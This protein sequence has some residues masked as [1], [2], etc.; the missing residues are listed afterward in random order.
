MATTQPDQHD[1]VVAHVLM[2]DIVG[3]SK[4]TMDE[5]RVVF[6]ELNLVVRAT[7]E[8][9]RADVA[10]QLISLPT[11]DGMALVFF[12]SPEAPVRCAIEIAHSL[13]E[14]SSI[15]LR[16]GIHS[17]PVYR[18]KDINANLNVSGGGINICQ[19]VM[20]SGDAGHILVS[21]TAKELLGQIREWDLRPLGEHEVKHGHRVTLF[22]LCAG[23]VGNPEV[24]SKVLAARMGIGPAQPEAAAAEVAKP[25]L[26][27]PPD[28]SWVGDKPGEDCP[29]ADPEAYTK[30]VAQRGPVTIR[31]DQSSI[32]LVWV[33]G[34]SLM[35]GSTH[36]RD[37]EKPVRRLTVDSFWVGRQ[38]VTVRQWQA[39][40]E[41]VPEKYND[42]GPLH[43][44]AAVTWDECR[45]FCQRTGLALPPEAYWEYA[46]R[47]GEGRVYPWG[48]Q[49]DASL[50]QC[51][52]NLH[53]R[54]RTAPA[55]SLADNVTWC[56]AR[57]MAGN[58]WEWCR[59]WYYP[60]P[61][62]P[63]SAPSGRRSLRGG[64]YASPAFEC[65]CSCRLSGAPGN[66]SP[67]VG[68]RVARP[69]V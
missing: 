48:N 66:R 65:R 14:G 2:V 34:G 11:G 26:N 49:W 9:N 38:P 35:M 63:G 8:Y 41:S 58:V 46:A 59:D 45:D 4:L 1:L 28:C 3:Y 18:V 61:P 6:R 27:L 51:Q 12:A 68:F 5:Q 10:D 39:I 53:G 69:K 32:E 36:G 25:E 37:D 50:C 13:A 47:G 19:R 22:N 43:P 21:N 40:M 33:A 44:V 57:D 20:D 64:S 7:R 52:E 16:M 42:Q 31:H 54:E 60:A 30:W 67:L 23:D 15:K 55:G 17:G 29:F 56:G 24:P 62:Q